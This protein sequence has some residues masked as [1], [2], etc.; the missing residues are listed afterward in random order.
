[1]GC[2]G[3]IIC[4]RGLSRISLLSQSSS[5]VYYIWA[6]WSIRCLVGDLK[7]VW[8][9]GKGLQKMFRR[10]VI[11][12]KHRGSALVRIHPRM[13]YVKTA[14][15]RILN[16]TTTVTTAERHYRKLMADLLSK[17]FAASQIFRKYPF[18]H[19]RPDRSLCYCGRYF[20]LCARCTTMYVG[21]GT[22][23]LTFPAW[24]TLPKTLLLMIGLLL[25]LPSA[26]DGTTQM[27][28]QRE[29]T[30]RLRLITGLLLGGGIPLVAWVLVS[31]VLP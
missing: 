14:D 12:A 30:N 18:C 7:K 13:W 24:Y 1:M 10:R 26:V 27:F 28:G 25:M 2:R 8:R 16:G 6:S 3:N 11:R 29:S 5:T 9:F 31:S 19:S 21:G 15:G 22:T 23:A 4:Y 20:G 17:A